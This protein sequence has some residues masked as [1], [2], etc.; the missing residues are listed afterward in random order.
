MQKVIVIAVLIT[1][2]LFTVI[3]LYYNFKNLSVQDN[4]INMFLGACIA[5]LGIL[6]GLKSLDKKNDKD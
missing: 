6:G 1:I 5:E 3:V 2:A 4:L